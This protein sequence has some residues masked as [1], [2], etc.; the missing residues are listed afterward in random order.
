MRKNS[1]FHCLKI[2]VLSGSL[3]LIGSAELLA[4]GTGG[5]FG[6]GTGGGTGGGF[7][8]GTGGGTG[9]GF[10]GGPGGGTGSFGGGTDSGFGGTGGGQGGNSVFQPSTSGFVGSVSLGRLPFGATSNLR[11]PTSGAGG[12]TGF[13]TSTRVGGVGGL[14]TGLGGIGGLGGLGGNRLNNNRMNQNQTAA[15]SQVRTT[16]SATQLRDELSLNTAPAPQLMSRISKSPRADLYQATQ[17]S[18]QGRIA[19]VESSNLPVA[20]IAKLKRYLA[21]EPGVDDVVTRAEL[22]AMMTE[23]VP[24]IP[25]STAP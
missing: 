1:R 22:Q 17:V 23:T 16:L 13:G 25:R 8:G 11:G 18:M 9:G 7:G 3:C 20:D 2:L 12:T 15:N 4:Q 5:G 24:A 19:V 14:G 10:G 6:G 21:L